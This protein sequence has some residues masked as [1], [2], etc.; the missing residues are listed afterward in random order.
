MQLQEKV[1]VIYGAAGSIGSAVARRFAAE[2]ATV[3]M[4]G[5]HLAPLDAV[6]DEI[7]AAGGTAKTSVVDAH[8]QAGVEA[9]ATAILA[10]TAGSMCRSTRSTTARSK[11]PPWSSLRWMTS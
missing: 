4:A 7:T 11:A 1:A 2:G 8:D 6:A 5:R 3:H 9:H 10:P